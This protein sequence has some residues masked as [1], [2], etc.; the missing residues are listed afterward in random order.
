MAGSFHGSLPAAFSLG[1]APK[2]GWRLLA[3]RFE[4]YLGRLIHRL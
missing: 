4:Y 2:S 1:I 3:M